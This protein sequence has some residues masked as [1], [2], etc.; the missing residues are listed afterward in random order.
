M[1]KKLYRDLMVH[2]LV[3]ILALLVVH[4]LGVFADFY[5]IFPWYDIMTHAW[6]GIVIGFFILALLTR[7]TGLSF[8]TK[9]HAVAWFT[10]ILAIAV[11]W[12]F[13][14]IF[15]SFLIP[16]YP[17]DLV[18]TLSDVMND[19]IGAYIAFMWSS[20]FVIPRY[21]QSDSD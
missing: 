2:T 8:G 4:S 18:D 19:L 17:F 15:V 20:R 21:T 12:E 14:E 6:G 1:R 16:V 13:Y 10:V 3:P 7:F 9:K 5:A 11:G